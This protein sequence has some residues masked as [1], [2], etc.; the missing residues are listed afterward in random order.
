MYN[1]SGEIEEISYLAGDYCLGFTDGYTLIE[2]LKELKELADPD[3]AEE[4]DY[5]DIQ[6]ILL[7]LH[8][9]FILCMI[10]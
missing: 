2:Q 4:Y 5:S 6:G 1:Y 10:Y 8:L 9:R 3:Y 7:H